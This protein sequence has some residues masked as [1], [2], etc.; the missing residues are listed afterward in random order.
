M[1]F[2]CD[3]GLVDWPMLARPAVFGLEFGET[4]GGSVSPLQKLASEVIVAPA[5]DRLGQ[6]S[7]PHVARLNFGR[8]G[9]QI[10]GNTHLLPLPDPPAVQQH[11]NRKERRAA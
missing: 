4:R 11:D 7:Q 6:E 5:V 3:L 2:G 10:R 1:S 9:Q 8:G